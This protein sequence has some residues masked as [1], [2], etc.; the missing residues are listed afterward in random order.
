MRVDFDSYST[1]CSVY[2]KAKYLSHHIQL[3]VVKN[4]FNLGISNN[5]V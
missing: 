3:P 5:T 4:L 2:I 1:R